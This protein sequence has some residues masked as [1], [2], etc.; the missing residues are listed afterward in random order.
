MKRVIPF[1]AKVNSDQ[2]LFITE[3]TCLLIEHFDY[4]LLLPRQPPIFVLIS[5][6]RVIC[7]LAVPRPHCVESLRLA[8][9]WTDLNLRPRA[10]TVR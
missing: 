1:Y 3:F 5:R 10:L 9:W 2:L 4:I 8:N 6:L 7:L